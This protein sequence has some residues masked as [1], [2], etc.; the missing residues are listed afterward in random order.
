MHR[1]NLKYLKSR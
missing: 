1:L